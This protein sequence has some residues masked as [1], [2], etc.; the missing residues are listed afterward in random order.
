MW[1]ARWR[2]ALV[3][4]V[5]VA[6]GCLP[7]QVPGAAAL[8]AGAIEAFRQRGEVFTTS[9]PLEGTLPAAAALARVRAARLARRHPDVPD[10]FAMVEREPIGEA[11]YGIASC[12]DP[13]MGPCTPG[14]SYGVW[15]MQ[16]PGQSDTGDPA[17]NAWIILDALTGLGLASGGR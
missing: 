5:V 13:S 4:M 2:L 9:A 1:V 10:G 6:A 3:L 12:V 16:F 17:P 14:E 8:P 15:V 11:V 7:Q